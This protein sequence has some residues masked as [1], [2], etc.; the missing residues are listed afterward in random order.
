MSTRATDEEHLLQQTGEH[1][2]PVANHQKSQPVVWSDV[3]HILFL[4]SSRADLPEGGIS[5]VKYLAPTYLCRQTA[6][7][8]YTSL[9][10][11]SWN[12]GELM[13]SVDASA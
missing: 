8:E 5:W 12:M 11:D 2:R 13:D 3:T 10:G 1:S 4:Q 6:Q 7:S 9:I